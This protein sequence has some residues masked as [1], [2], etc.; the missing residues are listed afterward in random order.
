MKKSLANAVRAVVSKL[1]RKDYEGAAFLSR[2]VRLSKAEIESAIRAYGK[3]LIDPPGDAFDSAEVTRIRSSGN[4]RWS[5]VVPFWTKEEGRS[6]LS[7]EVTIIEEPTLT[8][9]EIDNI[10][11]L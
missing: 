5:V 11:V 10:H 4:P 6:D 1:V 3:T 8:R 7:L 9:V 2:R